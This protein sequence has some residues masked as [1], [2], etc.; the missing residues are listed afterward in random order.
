[1][2]KSKGNVI[3]PEKI[4]KQYG[5]EILR[6]WVAVSEYTTDLKISDGI[7]KQVSEQYRKIRNTCRFL[8][9][10][11]EGLE[12]ILP[13]DKMGVLDKWILNHSKKVFDE[14]EKNF[15]DY[16]FSKGFSTL[17]H[18][19]TV[20]LSG[21]YL[22]ISKDR[23]YC[24][25]KDEDIRLSAQSATALITRRLLALIAPTLTYTVDEILEYAPKIIKEDLDDV[26]DMTYSSM[27]EVEVEFDSK[28]MMEARE[29]FFEI[30]DGMKKEKIIKSTLELD[31]V[32]TSEILL[33]MDSTDTEDWFTC[34]S[35]VASASG[36]E[37]GSFEIGE[38]K[39]KIVKAT[40][41]K[42]PRC[43]KFKAD[44]ED[45]LCKRCDEV[46]NA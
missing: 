8:L 9:A 20:E 23:L 27:D 6:L 21:I 32:T 14:V 22:D 39:F 13:Y 45:G 7:L 3:A 26:F 16:D 31:L 33:N 34:S 28:Y 11:C 25:G 19:I 12:K 36:E 41:H 38:D 29:K 18:F 15:R 43:W 40:A 10:N 4:S 24:N 1:M 44:K 17:S 42:C 2:S 46:I 5:V 35:V 30:I 37:M